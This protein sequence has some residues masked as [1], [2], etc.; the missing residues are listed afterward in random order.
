MIIVLTLVFGRSWRNPSAAFY[1]IGM[2]F[3]IVLGT[4]YFFNYIL[5]PRYYMKKKY[6]E[7]GLY[8]Y[9]T[10]VVS[11]YLEMLVLMFSF[12]YLGNF[13]L[14]NMSLNASD[15]LLLAVVM[16]LLVFLGCNLW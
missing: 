14:Y 10:V 5:V 12:I 2:L 6:L 15:T 1:F 8:T 4:S 13:N 11:V 3:P 16:Y 9:Y 7:F